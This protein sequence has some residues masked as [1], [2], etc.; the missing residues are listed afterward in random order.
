M[1]IKCALKKKKKK[2]EEDEEK[3]KTTGVK[4]IFYEMFTLTYEHLYL[5]CKT[6]AANKIRLSTLLYSVWLIKVIYYIP[7]KSRRQE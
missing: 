5:F 4:S 3:N 1:N 2:K 6:F 7:I